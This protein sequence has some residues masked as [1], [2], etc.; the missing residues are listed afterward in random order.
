MQSEL[1]GI[2]GG[3]NENDF[4]PL[5][6]Y[7]QPKGKP[8]DYQSTGFSLSVNFIK[9]GLVSRAALLKRTMPSFL[10]M[11]PSALATPRIGHH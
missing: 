8:A 10:K 1:R 11:T 7:G 4:V 5:T 6:Q 9:S 2:V 3:E